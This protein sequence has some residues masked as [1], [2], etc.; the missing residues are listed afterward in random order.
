MLD[1]TKQTETA[2]SWEN[3]HPSQTTE[4]LEANSAELAE[5]EDKQNRSR[6]TER[7]LLH[8]WSVSR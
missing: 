4:E 6:S 7:Y 8:T 1:N 3:S 5:K 2:A